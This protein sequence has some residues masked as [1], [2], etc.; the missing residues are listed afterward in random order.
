M[1]KRGKATDAIFMERKQNRV[2][3]LT[4]M[5][6]SLLVRLT[7]DIKD[8]NELNTKIESIGYEMGKRLVDDLI[9][10]FPRG[11]DLSD[12]NKLIEKLINQIAQYY[13][14][15]RGNYNQ[16]SDT[17]FHLF[18]QENP[19]SFYVEL[20]ESLSNLCY[21]NIICGIIRGALE[22]SGFEVTCEFVKDKMDKGLIPF[23]IKFEQFAPIPVFSQKNIRFID[24]IHRIQEEI[25]FEVNSV[26]FILK[27]KPIEI[28]S[29]YNKIIEDLKIEPFEIIQAKKK[30]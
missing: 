9:D 12:Q 8:I 6:G 22:I 7:K 5:Y 17:E 20:P 23:F 1:S 14:G 28:S 4:F 30:E 18:F 26:E 25:Q 11:Q 29:Y 3:L 10:D 21:S 15:I 27:G 16:V 19:I 2:E 24:I 13:L